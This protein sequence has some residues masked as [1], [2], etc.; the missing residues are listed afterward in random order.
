MPG[1]SYDELLRAMEGHV[2]ACALLNATF[3]GHDVEEWD[4]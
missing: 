2:V 4:G 1:A 3:E